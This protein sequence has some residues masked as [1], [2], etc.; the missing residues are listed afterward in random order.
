MPERAPLHFELDR[1]SSA[2]AEAIE[3]V[4]AA[5]R[6]AEEPER[7][8]L[9]WLQADL[10]AGAKRLANITTVSRGATP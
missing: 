10:A 8:A 6:L 5:A 7:G 2:L 4:D 1:A 9:Q 3:R